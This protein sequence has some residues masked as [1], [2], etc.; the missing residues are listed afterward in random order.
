[1]KR[2]FAFQDI[3]SNDYNKKDALFEKGLIHCN[4]K[5]PTLQ[6]TIKAINPLKAPKSTL[7]HYGL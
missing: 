3:T 2:A 4:S 7:E 5:N 6:D 1:M